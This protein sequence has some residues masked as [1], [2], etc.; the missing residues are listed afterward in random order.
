MQSQ[1]DRLLL[2][3]A[4]VSVLAVSSANGAVDLRLIPQRSAVPIGGEVTIDLYA[5]SDGPSTEYVS[6]MDVI[7]AWDAS[8]LQL[9][10]AQEDGPHSW[11][12]SGLIPDSQLDGLNDS[13]LDGDA[14]YT[15]ISFAPAPA[16]P[17]GLLV[18]NFRFLALTP[19]DATDVWIEHEYGSYSQTQ[20][21]RADAINEEITGDLGRTHLTLA[22]AVLSVHPL[23]IASGQSGTIVT[24]GALVAQDTF[25]VTVAI[26]LLPE[27]TSVGTVSFSPTPPV[28]IQVLNTPWPDN[29]TVTLFDTDKTGS[30][31]SNGM[32]SDN[33]QYLPTSV[34][35]DAR[36]AAFP[37]AA[38]GIARGH[39]KVVLNAIGGVH[40]SSWEGLPTALESAR[41][42]VLAACDGNGSESIELHDFAELQLCFT[43]AVGPAAPR[44]YEAGPD[45]WCNLYDADEDGD[46]DGSDFLAFHDKMLGPGS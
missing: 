41:L 1:I 43:G 12:M 16:S 23:T 19:A 32:V 25:G 7:I 28:D 29:G 6:A 14:L 17:Q 20:V 2:I 21:Y 13:L 11:S 40:S 18:A 8:H 37:I 33:G 30:D 9:L 34:T 22:Q 44:V 39:W 26:S 38:G 4:I 15:A 10:S 46:I 45:L 31:L 35:F 24:S 27:D 42:T 36:L 3:T 5:L